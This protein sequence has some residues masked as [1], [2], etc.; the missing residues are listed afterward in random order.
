L[1]A[2][3]EGRDQLLADLARE[4]RFVY[5]DRPLIAAT[6]EKAYAAMKQHLDAFAQPDDPLDRER[7][8]EALVAFP[9]PLAPL[10]SRRLSTSPPR[11][12]RPLL[13]AMTRR[14]YR[15][16]KLR[17]FEEIEVDGQRILTASYDRAGRRH[18]VLTA[19]VELSEL[20]SAAR[21]CADHDAPLPDGEPVMVDLYSEHA[22]LP[23]AELAQTLRR[24]L[25][26]VEF[27]A[28]INRIV[29]A[30]AAVRIPSGED[31]Y[32]FHGVAHENPKDE[33]LFAIAEVRDLTPV[34]GEDGRVVALPELEQM[35]VE[36]LEGIRTFQSH[37]PPSRRLYW[38]RL[39]LYVWPEIDL[40]PREVKGLL[41]RLAPAATGLGLE[42]LLLSGRVREHGGRAR[43]RVLR[44]FASEGG[45]PTIE[46]D[47]QPARPVQPLDEGARRIIAA[48]RRGTMHPA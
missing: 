35:L 21:A 16:R 4:T 44:I 6:T 38:N 23:P 8:I 14:Y 3:A 45:E 5:F 24:A 19:F 39:F 10:L 13:E 11:L 32:V 42:V 30:I 15:T 40:S 26:A 36:G 31:I 18:H 48:R 17:G 34:R 12:R 7:R 22:D 28:A 46:I 37:R 33:R 43:P 47:D 20:V 27:P 9:R 41:T 1:I 29:V 2:A 25:N